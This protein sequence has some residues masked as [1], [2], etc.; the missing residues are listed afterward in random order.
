MVART[1][2]SSNENN[3]DIPLSKWAAGIKSLSDI[4]SGFGAVV[5]LIFVIGTSYAT[6]NNSINL[7]TE[8]VKNLE[9]TVSEL[10]KQKAIDQALLLS[11]DKDRLLAN[12]R[13]DN[14]DVLHERLAVNYEALEGLIIELT[15]AKKS[16]Q[17]SAK[18]KK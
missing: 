2:P 5:A 11:L 14:N 4:M 1:Q 9:E 13:L 16:E 3:S 17:E 10:H 7:L 8:K 15:S 12:S 18:R 6:F